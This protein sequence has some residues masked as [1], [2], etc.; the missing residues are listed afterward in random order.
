MPRR[1]LAAAT[2][3][4]ALMV[5]CKSAPPRWSSRAP[6]PADPDRWE[7]SL[8]RLGIYPVEIDSRALVLARYADRQ[9]GSTGP[10]AAAA[11]LSERDAF[12]AR[13][14]ARSAAASPRAHAYAEVAETE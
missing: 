8:C 6:A 1:W 4:A 2:V 7:R 14:A 13:C 3:V 11:I 12:D 9:S 5:G 10:F